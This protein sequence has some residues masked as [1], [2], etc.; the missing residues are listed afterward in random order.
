[1]TLTIKKVAENLYEAIVTS[2]HAK[3][4]WSTATPLPGRALTEQLLS[5]GCHQTDI[6]DA[7]YEQDPEWIQKLE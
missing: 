7:M 1:M 2:P 4:D 6:G 5:L 3:R